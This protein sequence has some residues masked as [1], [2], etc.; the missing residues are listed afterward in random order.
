MYR[1][2]S[3]AGFTLLHL[4]VGA[5]SVTRWK[6]Q[7]LGCAVSFSVWLWW[8]GSPDPNSMVRPSGKY[9]RWISHQPWSFP[10]HSQ[11]PIGRPSEQ[12]V[13][14]SASS[15]ITC[16]H[17]E[18]LDQGPPGDPEHGWDATAGGFQSTRSTRHVHRRS[19]LR[20][21]HRNKVVKDWNIQLSFYTTGDFWGG[22]TAR[23]VG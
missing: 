17:P 23:F 14:L 1:S 8:I 11:V 9:S 21:K 13:G 6:F 15:W 4:P 12:M 2:I 18:F 5:A 16:N 22:S 19:L 10:G 7:R 3:K 20:P